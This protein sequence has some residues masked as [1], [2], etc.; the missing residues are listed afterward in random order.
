MST[1]KYEPRSLTI[2]SLL[3]WVKSGEIAIPE[4]QRPFVWDTTKVRNLLDSLF[5]DY[6]IG[7]LIVWKSPDVHLRDGSRSEG[8]KILI[9]G[10]QRITALMA[11]LLGQEVVTKDYRVLRIKIA[12]NPQRRSF[13][14]ANPAIEKDVSWISDVSVLFDPSIRRRQFVN[15]YCARNPGTIPDDIDDAIDALV[16]ITT[17]PI[18]IIE[19]DSSLDIETVTDIFIRVNSEGVPLSQAD[20]AMSKIAVNERYDGLHLRKAIDYFCHMAASPSFHDTIRTNDTAFAQTEYFRRM[21]WL[22]SENDDLYDPSYNDM[23]RVAFTSEFR[24]GRLQDLVALLSGRNFETRQYEDEIVADTFTRLRNGVLN[25]MNDTHFN[26]FIMIIR[27]AGFV[28][29]SLI[30]SQMSLNFAYML[31]LTLRNQGVANADIERHVRRWFVM[32]MLTGR[33]SGSPE[34]TIDFDIRQIDSIGIDTYAETTLSSQ[35]P[36]AFW[37][38]ALPQAMETSS[39]NS[40]YFNVFRAAQVKLNDKG[41]LSRDITVRELIEHRSDVH[42]IFPR[43]LLKRAGMSRGQYNQIANYAVAQSEINIQIGNRAPQEYLQHLV[44][45]VNGGTLRYGSITNGAELDENLTTHC[46]PVD[47]VHMSVQ[48]YAD[49]LGARRVLMAER[50]RQYFEML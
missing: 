48:D 33:Y 47:L 30:G 32:S 23:L 45:Q 21:A 43:D 1:R 14:V 26:R 50:I 6:P 12:F 22:R 4:I 27:S 7:Y 46:I 2:S 9:D 16:N 19:L 34:S 42:H 17:N 11:A 25:F 31:Y 39:A 29:A 13:E 36:L 49:F 28:D 15:E 38:A 10:Q 44:E 35:L 20:F 5:Q 41:F 37:Q 8:K 3:N 18:G 40:P 24:R